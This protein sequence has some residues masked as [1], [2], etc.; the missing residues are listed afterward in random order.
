MLLD[1]KVL[2]PLTTYGQR[3]EGLPYQALRVSIETD[4]PVYHTEPLTLDGLLAWA[5]VWDTYQGQIPSYGPDPWQ[6]PLP[7]QAHTVHNGWPLWTSTDFVAINPHE[8]YTHY[9]KRTGDNPYALAA[10]TPTL[11]Q[12]KVRR[13][14]SSVC[15]QYMDYRIPERLV[16]AERWEADCVGNRDE[17]ARLLKLVQHIGKGSA[18]GRGRVRKI[19]IRE[20]ERFSF[21]DEAGQPRRPIPAAVPLEGLSPTS[22]KVCGWTPAYW[23]AKLWELCAV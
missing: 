13:Q 15:G 3:I 10:M 7:L 22:F 23:Q 12:K 18:R 6:I 11:D 1:A 4:F 2:P 14:P 17:I 9:H 8:S 20:I 19:E 16:V 21:L 5:V